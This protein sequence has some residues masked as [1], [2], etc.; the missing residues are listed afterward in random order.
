MSGLEGRRIASRIALRGP[1]R[2]GWL[3]G[4]SSPAM[5]TKF[6]GHLPLPFLFRLRFP[7]GGGNGAA[8]RVCNG[9]GDTGSSYCRGAAIAAGGSA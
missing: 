1:T 8:H 7:E 6:Y 4:V 5:A 3:A 2:K 9:R